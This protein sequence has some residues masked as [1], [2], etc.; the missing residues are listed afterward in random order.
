MPM[1]GVRPGISTDAWM[2]P[3]RKMD[4]PAHADACAGTDG[5]SDSCSCSD[6]AC[7]PSSRRATSRSIWS[8][9]GTAASLRRVSCGCVFGAGFVT[10]RTT[11]AWLVI[12]LRAA[13][14][15]PCSYALP[16]PAASS[17]ASISLRSASHRGHTSMPPT[18]ANT[19]RIAA[20]AA[21]LMS[22]WRPGFS[23]AVLW[24]RVC[25]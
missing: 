2:R 9:Y 3:L 22:G 24:M 23:S 11:A 20:L 15:A 1:S 25:R 17:L 5:S 12:S 7:G 6:P 16:T 10:S 18:S 13:S 4:V 14:R 19:A 8:T 21:V